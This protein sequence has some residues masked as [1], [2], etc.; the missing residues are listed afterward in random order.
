MIGRLAIEGVDLYLCRIK[1]ILRHATDAL[2]LPTSL[3]VELRSSS[4]T[5]WGEVLLPNPGLLWP[6]ARRA[7]PLLL[8][9][10]ATLLDEPASL[11]SPA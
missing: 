7:A 2:H 11:V 8:D 9:Q 1:S 5:G 4:L 10:D 6:W 3:I